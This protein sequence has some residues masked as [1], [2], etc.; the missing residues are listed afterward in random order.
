MNLRR[1]V[2][3]AV[4]ALGRIGQ[5]CGHERLSHSRTLAEGIAIWRCQLCGADVLL[6]EDSALR[7]LGSFSTVRGRS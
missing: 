1:P 5:R 7:A 2:A 3:V 4:R 6:S